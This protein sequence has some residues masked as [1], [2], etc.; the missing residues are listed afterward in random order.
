MS[1]RSSKLSTTAFPT[2]MLVDIG[3]GHCSAQSFK[4]TSLDGKKEA[5]TSCKVTCF[6]A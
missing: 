5:E 1:T 4:F 2:V 6:S 3:Q